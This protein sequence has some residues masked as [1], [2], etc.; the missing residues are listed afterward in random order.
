MGLKNQGGD[1]TE[2]T[3]P[4][5]TAIILGYRNEATIVSAVQSVVQ[6]SGP[7]VQVLVVTSGPDSGASA[8]RAMYPELVVIEVAERLMPGGARNRGLELASGEV[9]GF[10]AADCLARPGWIHG[11]RN[12]HANGYVA[13]SCAIVS[14]G[15]PTPWA[16]ASWLVSYS[17]RLPGYPSAEVER[18]SARRHGLS[19]DRV[20]V[21]ELGGYD[22]NLR[23]GE[24]SKMGDQ[25]LG[26]G[27]K[28]WFENSIR[29]AHR[30]PG[31]TRALV[32]DEFRRGRLARAH[33]ELHGLGVG[34]FTPLQIWTSV[35]RH[36]VASGW[37]YG[38]I[39]KLV[40][41]FSIPWIAAASA[42]Q[43]LGARMPRRGGR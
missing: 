23:I 18:S 11:H 32:R 41:M 12:A 26:A 25:I 17:N 28:I 3:E 40:V 20:V 9:V 35:C 7:G 6:Q 5:F 13:V 16:V 14:H 39:S 43:L 2:P 21:E 8:V 34:T 1:G 29:I 37:R 38:Q 36:S 19:V 30:G 27:H 33:R 31:N 15:R 10:L 24:D 22:A 4:S 42:C